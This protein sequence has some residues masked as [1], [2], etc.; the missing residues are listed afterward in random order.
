MDTPTFDEAMR[1]L[2]SQPEEFRK[3]WNLNPNLRELRGLHNETLLHFLAVEEEA[4]A[5][6]LLSELGAD[7]NA[8]NE[9]GDTALHDCVAVADSK[10]SALLLSLGAN[11]NKQ[12]AQGYTALHTAFE[13]AAGDGIFQMLL[14][15]G[16]D[17]SL[18]NNYGQTPEGSFLAPDE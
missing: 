18:K 4:A 1:V 10:M 2:V 15:A 11:P 14:K 5:V 17:M 7:V 12:N 8:T 13:N 6:A 16:G 9:H 3:L